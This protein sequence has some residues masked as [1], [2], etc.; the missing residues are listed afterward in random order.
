MLSPHL[1]FRFRSDSVATE[2]VSF[3]KG[4]TVGIDGGDPFAALRRDHAARTRI[5]SRTTSYLTVSWLFLTVSWLSYWVTSNV[6]NK[7]RENPDSLL[8]RRF[9]RERHYDYAYCE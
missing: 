9:H 6:M 4:H 5:P 1:S 3:P 7:Y 8:Q 2:S